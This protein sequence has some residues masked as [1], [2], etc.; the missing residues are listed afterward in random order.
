MTGAAEAAQGSTISGFAAT[1][2][3]GVWG[4]ATLAYALWRSLYR[5]DPDPIRPSGPID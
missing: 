4:G 3:L 2:V 1:V 5:P